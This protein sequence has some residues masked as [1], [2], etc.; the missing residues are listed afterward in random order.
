MGRDFSVD[1]S[2]ASV[3]VLCA[4]CDWRAVRLTASHART[5]AEAHVRAAHA[6]A[7]AERVTENARQRR[8]RMT[9]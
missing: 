1:A 9:A 4:H 2:G 3:V 5:E 8:H 6:G 7:P